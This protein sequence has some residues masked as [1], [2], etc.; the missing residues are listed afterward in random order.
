[1][2]IKT[3]VS[4]AIAANVAIGIHLPLD[5]M[6]QVPAEILDTPEDAPVVDGA[7][8]AENPI[9]SSL[10]DYFKQKIAE[11]TA[12]ATEEEK[13]DEAAPESEDEAAP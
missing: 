3:I 10:G 6:L 11:E 2:N 9:K 5:Q 4:T 8:P 13:K 12:N 7:A 1:M